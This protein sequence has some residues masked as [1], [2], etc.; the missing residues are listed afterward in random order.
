MSFFAGDA[1][2][3]RKITDEDDCSKLQGDLNE[4][5]GVRK[6]KWSSKKKS[7]TQWKWARVKVGP[8]EWIRLE[9]QS[10]NICSVLRILLGLQKRNISVHLPL[11][12]EYNF[13]TLFWFLSF[14]SFLFHLMLC[15]I[16]AQ[17]SVL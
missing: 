10:E 14:I 8:V 15:S 12:G 5:H 1:K 2:V 3:L 7:F 13:F 9:G 17:P 6:G 4:I 11:K 16:M